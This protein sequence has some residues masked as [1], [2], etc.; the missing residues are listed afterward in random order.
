MKSKL[1]SARKAKLSLALLSILAVLSLIFYNRILIFMS[2]SPK[3]NSNLITEF[4]GNYYMGDGLGLSCVFSINPDATFIIIWSTDT[5][6]TEEYQGSISVENMQFL[7]TPNK[8]MEKFPPC[9]YRTM[10]P[11]NWGDR[12][13]LLPDD[14]FSKHFCEYIKSGEEPRNQW[15]GYPYL[16]TPDITIL[17]PGYPTK[18]NGQLQCPPK[19]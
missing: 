14:E 11:L 19:Q 1:L 8:K 4:E 2:L 9:F 16:Y 7:L 15:F 12:R 17:V 18:P 13:Y 10:I 5:G 3:A 6:H